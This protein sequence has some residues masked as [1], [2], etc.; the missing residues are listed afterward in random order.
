MQRPGTPPWLAAWAAGMISPAPALLLVSDKPFLGQILVVAFTVTATF[1]GRVKPLGQ[2]APA[3]WTAAPPVG[4]AQTEPKL[5][6]DSPYS[7]TSTRVTI[8]SR[9][10]SAGQ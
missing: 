6:E 9:G 3:A 10:S 8:S 2:T 4:A 7:T 5:A 1:F